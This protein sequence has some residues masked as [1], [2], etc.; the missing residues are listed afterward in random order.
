M[1]KER[2][3]NIHVTQ[4]RQ[5]FGRRV[6]RALGGAMAGLIAELL[7][8]H[9]LELDAPPP[10]PLT[11]LFGA[12]VKDVWLEIGFGGGE[13]LLWQ[14]GANPETGYIGCEPFLSGA[15]KAL[16]GIA[17]A[18]LRN[19]R[20]HDDDARH[21][22]QWLPAASLGRVF[23]LFPDPWPKRRH[24]K[25]RFLSDE[26]LTLIARVLRPGGQ[27]RFAT[28]IAD[29]AA[30]VSAAVARRADFREAP[31]LLAERPADWPLT[32]YA[33]KAAAAGRRCQFFIFE[34]V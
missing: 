29:Y 9:R 14:A 16:R 23:I 26:G 33:Q 6:G 12:P 10:D 11:G 28:D 32:R 24:R 8:A 22:L 13:H 25:R 3:T 21:V 15:G 5:L 27:L 7:P 4:R 2:G 34:R 30:M 19:V 20:L 18:G 31:G 17:G 1:E